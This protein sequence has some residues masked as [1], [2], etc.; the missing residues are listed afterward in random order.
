MEVTYSLT[1][2]MVIAVKLFVLPNPKNA[3]ST[4]RL[5]LPG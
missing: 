4:G 5:N 2:H 3:S 1:Q